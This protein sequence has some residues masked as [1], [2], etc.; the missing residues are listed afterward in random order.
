MQD[1]FCLAAEAAAA[2]AAAA[3][4]QLGRAFAIKSIP[5]FIHFAVSC[6]SICPVF[7][8]AHNCH[9]FMHMFVLCSAHI[10]F[11][12]LFCVLLHTIAFLPCHIFLLFDLHTN[13][14]LE[15]ILFVLCSAHK[16]LS[17]MILLMLWVCL[18]K[19]ALFSC[20]LF[21][22]PSL[23]VIKINVHLPEI[24]YLAPLSNLISLC[25]F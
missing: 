6:K 10:I 21:F 17:G 11:Y 16:L 4:T 22:F 14:F 23:L 8:S 18:A 12:I 3:A 20:V 1:F 9:P 15:C 2:A 7:F 25:L 13:S 5:S 19:C 24:V